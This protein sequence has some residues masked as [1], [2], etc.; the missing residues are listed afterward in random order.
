LL[1]NLYSH[2]D[3][4]FFTE[5]KKFLKNKKTSTNLPPALTMGKLVLVTLLKM[6]LEPTRLLKAAAF[7]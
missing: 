6:G 2:E 7:P 3:S 1:D 4:I 5:N